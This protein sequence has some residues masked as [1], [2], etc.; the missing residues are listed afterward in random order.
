MRRRRSASTA[1]AADLPAIAPAQDKLATPKVVFWEPLLR[2]FPDLKPTEVLVV[3]AYTQF[4]EA[5]DAELGQKLGISR[6]TVNDIRNSDRWGKLLRAL[7]LQ[8]GD[9]C[10]GKTLL[11]WERWLDAILHK[12]SRGVQPSGDDCRALEMLAKRGGLLA[13]EVQINVQGD[14]V[15]IVGVVSA[16][17]AKMR[18]VTSADGDNSAQA[19]GLQGSG[20]E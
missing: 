16:A 12:Q 15:S 20:V 3:D 4:P 14:N 6:Q 9:A 8:R 11:V 18:S 10:T 19:V 2:Q 5:T 13:P 1:P 17:I 7:M